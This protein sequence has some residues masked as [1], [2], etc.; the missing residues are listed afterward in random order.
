MARQAQQTGEGLD[1]REIAI[2]DSADSKKRPTLCRDRGLSAMV[3]GEIEQEE[4][5]EEPAEMGDPG[6]GGAIGAG[7]AGLP[8]DEIDDDPQ[9]DDRPEPAPGAWSG[10]ELKSQHAA[11]QAADRAGGADD[12]CGRGRIRGKMR[13]GSDDAADQEKNQHAPAADAP[14]D[15]RTEGK[16]RK[17]IDAEMYEATVEEL[18]GNGIGK[19]RPTEF[20][21]LRVARRDEREG[22]HQR[23]VNMRRQQQPQQMHGDVDDQQRFGDRW[24][25]ED[26]LPCWRCRGVAH[27]AA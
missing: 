27:A 14:L 17:H 2:F 6:D 8:D 21:R 22:R 4:A 12:R 20:T 9:K 15:A 18:V 24:N 26:G 11:E 1:E 16:Q 5:G 7:H 25:V 23:V 10:A 3:R 13:G 19:R